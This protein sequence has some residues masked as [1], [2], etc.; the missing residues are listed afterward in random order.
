MTLL[1]STTIFLSSVH[2]IFTHPVG[3]IEADA[4]TLFKDFPFSVFILLHSGVVFSLG[5]E[6]PGLL[7]LLLR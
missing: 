5:V 1:N 4:G 6:F 2:H 3:L 7:D